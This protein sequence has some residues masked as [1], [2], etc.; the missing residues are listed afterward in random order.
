MMAD[1]A[2]SPMTRLRWNNERD[3]YGAFYRA[4]WQRPDEQWAATLRAEEL[5]LSR[6]DDGQAKDYSEG[7]G[8]AIQAA[9]GRT[10][11]IHD[12]VVED[13]D[14][15]RW[16][17][18]SEGYI[19]VE[20][21]MLARKLLIEADE[22]EFRRRANLLCTGDSPETHFFDAL[23]RAISTGFV[24]GELH[25]RTLEE[26]RAWAEEQG[27]NVTVGFP[28]GEA[29]EVNEFRSDRETVDLLMEVARERNRPVVMDE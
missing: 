9:S 7:R 2:D 26:A 1:L 16:C 6:L 27:W 23:E 15:C 3:T 4:I 25:L 8:F 18:D 28:I 5:L 21:K 17:L 13:S 19:P 29:Y 20:D 14:G 10:Y 12:N 22:E 24:G 11:R